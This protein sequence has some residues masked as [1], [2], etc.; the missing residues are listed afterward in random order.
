M[1]VI[2]SAVQETKASLRRIFTSAS[3]SCWP[4]VGTTLPS[5]KLCNDLEN[6]HVEAVNSSQMSP[7]VVELA[8]DVVEII[9]C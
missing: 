3:C 5:I 8:S 9:T 7:V 1:L 4:L 6:S 2:Q